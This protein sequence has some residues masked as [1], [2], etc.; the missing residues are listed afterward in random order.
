MVELTPP[1]HNDG[2]VPPP[3]HVLGCGCEQRYAGISKL[4][5]LDILDITDQSRPNPGTWNTL[6]QLLVS[7]ELVTELAAIALNSKVVDVDP[8]PPSS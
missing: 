1:D 5:A 3:H 2:K 7:L 6:L 8:H 4:N